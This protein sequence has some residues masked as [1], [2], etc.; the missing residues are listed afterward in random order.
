VT[1]YRFLDIYGGSSETSI[2]F[3]QTARRHIQKIKCS[4][5]TLWESQI[6]RQQ[7]NIY[8]LNALRFLVLQLTQYRTCGMRNGYR[9][10]VNRPLVVGLLAETSA[11]G[12]YGQAL[13]SPE[14]WVSTKQVNS[15]RYLLT[16]DE[17]SITRTRNFEWNVSTSLSPS[18]VKHTVPREQT[19][20]SLIFWS[21][22]ISYSDDGEES[23]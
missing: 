9:F 7:M 22:W 15:V 12:Q 18:S 11:L 23:V 19:L 5:L 17:R 2:N 1:L 3:Y 8:T 10:T 16:R 6:Q 4:S 20:P 14:L 21:M 13:R